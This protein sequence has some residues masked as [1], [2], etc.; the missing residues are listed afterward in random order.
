LQ[1]EKKLISNNL[2]LGLSNYFGR[3]GDWLDKNL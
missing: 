1:H 2:S 3:I